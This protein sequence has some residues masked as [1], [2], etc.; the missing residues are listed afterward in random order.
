M[1]NWLPCF[2]ITL[3]FLL[4]GISEA[5]QFGISWDENDQRILGDMTLQYVK[6]NNIDLLSS[7]NREYGSAFELT[8]AWLT[9][10]FRKTDIKN[11]YIFRHQVTHL[12]F[13]ISAAAV[14]YIAQK[15]SRNKLLAAI[16]MLMYL[17]SPRIY[18]H[19]FYNTKDIPF[20]CCLAIT[21]AVTLLAFSK[22]KTT[23]YVLVGLVAGYTTSIRIMGVMLFM[24]IGALCLAD[25]IAQRREK[26]TMRKT[27]MNLG[28]F[29]AI[30]MLATYTFWPYI[31]H[32][33]LHKFVHAYTTMA[34]YKWHCEVLLDGQTIYATNLP[35]WYL[36]RWFSITLPIAWLFFGLAGIVWLIAD[37]LRAP[38][39]FIANGTERH[40]LLYFLCFICP[41]SAVLL[42]HSV[43]YDDWR[44]VYFVYAPFTLMALYFLMK[45]FD[46]KFKKAA[47]SLFG[48]QVCMLGYFMVANARYEY[49]YFNELV[50]NAGEYIRKNY[51]LDYWG[52]SCRQALEY[53]ARTD[54]KDTILISGNIGGPVIINPA[55]LD[56]PDRYRFKWAGV[57][58]SDY[59]ITN[60]RWHPD[61]YDKDGLPAN[62]KV[63]NIMVNNSSII[64]VYKVRK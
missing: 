58:Q 10:L 60:Y 61:D 45:V 5:P 24:F 26:A 63:F 16:T 29:I 42:L 51:E 49:L 9:Q 32:N 21:L 33:P 52:L 36:P 22:N 20:L 7:A 31:W 40:F 46:T 17:L 37:V 23:Y 53:I 27:I 41:V 39:K 15:L 35:W 64:T 48:I 56:S 54:K 8:L 43:V 14:Y 55:I 62:K 4:V 3:F 6:G 1:K 12:L 57:W 18:G 38:A 13:L 25:I 19:S 28:A 50:P 47:I 30:Y 59:F 2:L 44:H 11:I 34:H